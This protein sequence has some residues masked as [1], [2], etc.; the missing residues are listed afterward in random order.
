MRTKMLVDFD[1]GEAIFVRLSEQGRNVRSARGS[2]GENTP[3]PGIGNPKS[4]FEELEGK[5]WELVGLGQNGDA[6]L[7]EDT[8]LY[9][10]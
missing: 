7:L 1:D 6:R 10:L 5:L 3:F 4:A 8:L 2:A 9:H